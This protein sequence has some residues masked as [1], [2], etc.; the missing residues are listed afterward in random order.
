MPTFQANAIQVKLPDTMSGN[1][2][3]KKNRMTDTSQNEIPWMNLDLMHIRIETTDIHRIELPTTKE[4]ATTLAEA[5]GTTLFRYE[6]KQ[7]GDIEA[8]FDQ[9][10][11]HVTVP[12]Q[13][14]GGNRTVEV[15]VQMTGMDDSLRKKFEQS[16]TVVRK[17]DSSYTTTFNLS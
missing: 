14:T 5:A 2:Q 6:V 13:D 3:G 10:P 8:T 17:V 1:N 4:R 15:T 9:P 16:A 12:K 7:N 11:T